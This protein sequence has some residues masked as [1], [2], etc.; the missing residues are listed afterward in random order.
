MLRVCPLLLIES[1]TSLPSLAFIAA[2]TAVA[3][4]INSVAGG[5]TILTFPALAAILPADPARLVIANATSTIGLW[6]G[7]LSATW[8][9]R[10]ERGHHPKWSAWLFLPSIAGSVIGTLLVLVLPTTYF[11]SV[12]PVLI[13]LAA[14][15][16]AIQP[17]ISKHFAK[18]VT[19]KEHDA[20]NNPKKKTLLFAAG[21][22]FFIGI[23]GGYFGAGIGI[24]MLAALGGLGLGDAHRLNGFKN[25]LAMGINACAAITFILTGLFTAS[26]VAWPEAGIMAIAAILGGLVGGRLARRSHPKTIRK[27]VAVIGF[28]LAGYYFIT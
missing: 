21:V 28:G 20:N 5:G 7:T 16:F 4:A 23:Y 24:L 9:Y 12:V 19:V 2:V 27:I 26:I 18:S 10:H 14:T 22:Q 13:F 25:L 17:L 3:A 8:E 11:D 6:P 1:A 15:L